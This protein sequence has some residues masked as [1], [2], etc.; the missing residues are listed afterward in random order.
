MALKEKQILKI[1]KDLSKN[2]ICSEKFQQIILDEMNDQEII[3]LFEFSYNL[4]KK[5]YKNKK[6]SE[7]LFLKP[8]R[9]Q[10]VKILIDNNDIF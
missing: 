4:Q 7:M 5:L 9:D 3:K 6:N 2:D 1:L 8:L 10:L